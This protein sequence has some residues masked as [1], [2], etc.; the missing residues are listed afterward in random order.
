MDLE[1]YLIVV[2]I[3]IYFMFNHVEYLFKCW[4]ASPIG[5]SCYFVWSVYKFLPIH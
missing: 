1:W 4:L 5:N 3:Y 2:L